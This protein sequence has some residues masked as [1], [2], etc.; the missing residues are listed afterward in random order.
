MNNI[1]VTNC[2]KCI[3]DEMASRLKERENVLTCDYCGFE[4][5][6]GF[7]R[8]EVH[9]R[10]HVFNL[11]CLSC[12]DYI[13]NMFKLTALY[14][15]AVQAQFN[16]YMFNKEETDNLNPFKIVDELEEE[17]KKIDRKFI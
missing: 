15:V 16:N 5:N 6:D 17:F 7:Y 12:L 4:L 9:F 8:G 13:K 1:V 14:E 3:C 2:G 11:L 10:N